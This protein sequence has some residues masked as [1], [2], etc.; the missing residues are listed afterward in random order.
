MEAL[1]HPKIKD[2]LAECR[3]V[4]TRRVYSSRIKDFF[5]YYAKGVDSFLELPANEKRHVAILYQND[6]KGKFAA[7]SING[8]LGAL[9]SFLDQYD[10]K[11]NFKGKRVRRTMD[12][13]SHN[14]SNGDLAAMFELGNT[15]EKALLS[16]A[17]SLG[18]EVSAV[19]GLE[20]KRIQD[21]V[22]RA[23]AE[24][25]Q[26]FYFIDQRGKTGV[27]RLGILNPL[28]LE[29]LEK[30][31]EES[32]DTPLR[33]RWGT[34]SR[35][36][37]VS[38]LFDITSEGANKILRRLARETHIKTTGRV[39][40]HKLR[41][42]VISGLSRAGFNEFQLKYAV[43]KAIPMTD[44]TYLQTIEEQIRERYPEAYE[45]YLNIKTPVRA[46]TELTKS[47]EEKTRELNE[48]KAK[49]DRI[50]GSKESLEALLLRVMELEKRLDAES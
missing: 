21:Y 30:W 11:V 22:N 32:K 34:E 8:T 3:S 2:W 39:H 45:A 13:N 1:E 20:R 7:N 28:A 25:T 38:D 19:L 41:S 31:L 9:N 18:W 17:V 49:V 42:W 35:D 33:K 36:R 29:W 14:F 43:G 47:L 48:L 12:I 24:D 15:K 16:L 26:F 6:R 44:F 10:M 46:M 37:V 5:S 4:H 27:P 23:K 40:F 50:E